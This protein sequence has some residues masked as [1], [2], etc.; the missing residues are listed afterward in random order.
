MAGPE[1]RATDNQ[2]EYAVR[3]AGLVSCAV[4][5]QSREKHDDVY[6][7]VAAWIDGYITAANQY[8]PDTYDAAPFESTELFLTI[9]G[10]YCRDHPKVPVVAVL[11]DVMKRIWPDRL[12]RKSEKV[13]ITHSG[14]STRL[15]VEI[16]RRMQRKLQSAGYYKGPIDGTFSSRTIE[17]LKAFQKSI[18]FKP[19]GFPDQ[20]TLWRLL[21]GKGSVHQLQ[22]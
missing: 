12:T 4:F 15:Y 17:A 16:I 8:A 22:G 3:G 20:A 11:L 6:L 7:V 21:Q 9:A 1:A 13:P 2:G 5:N 14:H 10:Q 19:T 18:A